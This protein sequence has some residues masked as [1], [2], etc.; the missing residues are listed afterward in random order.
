MAS[1]CSGAIK[2][3]SVVRGY[4]LYKEIW[5]SPLGEIL[6][7]QQKT[8]NLHDRFAV[9]IVKEIQVVG[10]IRREISLIWSIF[11]LAGTITYGVSGS[12]QYSY[13]W[14]AYSMQIESYLFRLRTAEDHME[15]FGS[16]F[17]EN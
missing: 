4:R 6:F 16:R 13:E 2:I 14:H 7:C 15:T 9:A 3:T 17:G 10:H 5:A 12:R 1:M 11:L 8:D